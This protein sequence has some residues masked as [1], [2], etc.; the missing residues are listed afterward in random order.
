MA[1]FTLQEEGADKTFLQLNSRTWPGEVLEQ[2][3]G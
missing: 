3:Q 2:K 1:E